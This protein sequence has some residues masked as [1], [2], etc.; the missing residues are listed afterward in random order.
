MLQKTIQSK[1]KT[2][3][4]AEGL[5][6]QMLWPDK[7]TKDVYYEHEPVMASSTASKEPQIPETPATNNSS[8]PPPAP[9]PEAQST[10][11]PKVQSN[12]GPPAGA[13]LAPVEDR[14]PAASEI[15]LTLLAKSLKVPTEQVAV[16][17]SIK[18]LTG[19]ECSTA[20]LMEEVIANTYVITRPLNLRK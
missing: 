3:D 1:F 14:P 10:P 11:A 4:L 6:R 15:L 5:Q 7:D 9:A 19:G 2:S 18:A 13:T 12:P 17:K 16:S 20:S 8:T